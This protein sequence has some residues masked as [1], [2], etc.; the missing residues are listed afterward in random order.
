MPSLVTVCLPSIF[1]RTMSLLTFIG[2]AWRPLAE[3]IDACICQDHQ[4]KMHSDPDRD[5]FLLIT[6]YGFTV[7]KEFIYPNSY[8]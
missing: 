6:R 4:A 8:L 2:G 7:C 1:Y 3:E 5:N